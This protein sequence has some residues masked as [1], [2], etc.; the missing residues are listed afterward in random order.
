M[1]WHYGAIV[2]ARENNDGL[3]LDPYLFVGNS[4]V[5]AVYAQLLKA[6]LYA[7]PVLPR[8]HLGG[9]VIFIDGAVR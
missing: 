3:N 5:S 2:N 4:V 9:L 1:I 8:R 6:P 7:G